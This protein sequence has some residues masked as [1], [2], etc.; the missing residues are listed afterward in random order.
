[1]YLRAHLA[2]QLVKVQLGLLSPFLPKLWIVDIEILWTAISNKA[3]LGE[4]GARSFRVKLNHLG[5]T[6]KNLV[7]VFLTETKEAHSR[8]LNMYVHTY[9]HT[10]TQVHTY[11]DLIHTYILYWYIRKIVYTYI[12]MYIQ[13]YI[14]VRIH[15]HIRMYIMILCK[16][17]VY[18]WYT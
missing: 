14:Y 9:I 18:D 6:L 15:K 13:K 4:G 11:V 3:S 10:Y 8:M 1:M 16:H 17:R 12:H 2:G 5:S 7:N